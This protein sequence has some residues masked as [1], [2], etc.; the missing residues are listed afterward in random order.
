MYIK[1]GEYQ[2]LPRLSKAAG[3]FALCTE[4]S[5][6]S[7]PGNAQGQWWTETHGDCTQW[8]ICSGL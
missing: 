6:L 3:T 5:S 1:E 4:V 8:S 2:H 7:W